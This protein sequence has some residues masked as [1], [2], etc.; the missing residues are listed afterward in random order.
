MR[1]AQPLHASLLEGSP[2]PNRTSQSGCCKAARSA[3]DTVFLL[4]HFRQTV[5][6]CTQTHPQETRQDLHRCFDSV[7]SAFNRAATP[8]LLQDGIRGQA[9]IVLSRLSREQ[10]YLVL[11]LQAAHQLQGARKRPGSAG[12][13]RQRGTE[14]S[15]GTSAW[16]RGIFCISTSFFFVEQSHGNYGISIKDP[17]IAL[18]CRHKTQHDITSSAASSVLSVPPCSKT[19]IQISPFTSTTFSRLRAALLPRCRNINCSVLK[20]FEVSTSARKHL[21]C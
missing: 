3:S 7:K 14:P 17:E 10:V 20:G 5:F 19:H 1:Q 8:M 11:E 18:H 15:I 12:T 16:N 13:A 6:S 2:R 4:K 9:G 21:A